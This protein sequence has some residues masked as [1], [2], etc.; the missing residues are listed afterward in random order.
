MVIT[1]GQTPLN[2][3]THQTDAPPGQ[4]GRR[5]NCFDFLRL[6]AAFCVLVSH[7]EEHLGLQVLWVSPSHH[8]L[9]FYDGVPLFFIMSGYLVY[10]SYER[11]VTRGLPIQDYFMN[12]FLRIAPGLYAYLVGT[13]ALMLALQV[14]HPGGLLSFGYLGWAIETILLLPGG[15]GCFRAF[16]P[17][18]INGSLWTIP[19]EFSFY[20]VV[21]L[22]YYVEK[23]VGAARTAVGM[24]VCSA[25][26]IVLLASLEGSLAGR[27]L[28]LTFLP[29]LIFFGLGICWSKWWPRCPQRLPVALACIAIYAGL[30]MSGAFEIGYGALHL[31]GSL[32]PLYCFAWAVPLS[33]FV[34]YTA[35]HGPRFLSQITAKIGDLSYG[36]YIWHMIVVQT[37]LYLLL[38]ARLSA[39]PGAT[40]TLVIV[41]S[42][43]VAALS[44]HFIEKPALKKKRYS[45]RATPDSTPV[46]ASDPNGWTQAYETQ[47][48]V[49]VK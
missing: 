26:G 1:I 4:R 11:C 3:A 35:Y 30:R 7:S 29:Y 40:Q 42:F 10:Q 18:G 33:Y 5:Q 13:T 25:G 39:Y 14:L 43:A 49:P 31:R 20:I 45:L 2:S 38:P 12:R 9:W 24:A 46:A 34:L 48:P 47:R 44:W 22:I 41:T 17:K 23:R 16:A 21:P 27:L 6:L 15:G 19:A 36:L 32:S 37:A 28:Q 8:S